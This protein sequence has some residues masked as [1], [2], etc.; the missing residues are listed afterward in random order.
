MKRENFFHRYLLGESLKHIFIRLLFILLIIIIIWCF[1]IIILFIY[2]KYRKRKQIENILFDNTLNSNFKRNTR[3][4]SSS[5]SISTTQQKCSWRKRT[6]PIRYKT[7]TTP[8]RSLL[9]KRNNDLQ[10]IKVNEHQFN[11]K[12]PR[13]YHQPIRRFAN[14]QRNFS[15]NDADL[16]LV[17]ITDTNL[18]YTN[19]VELETFED[20]HGL[21]TDIEKRMTRQVKASYRQRYS[22]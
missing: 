21:M 8:R 22:T 6:N 13:C 11:K 7:Q 19:V 2:I 15:L 1:I 17:M 18:S 3:F 5:T 4:N 14:K 9:I 16:P 12:T 10:T 20:K